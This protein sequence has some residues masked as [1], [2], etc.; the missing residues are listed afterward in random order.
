[1]WKILGL[2]TWCNNSRDVR[3]QRNRVK[4]KNPNDAVYGAKNGTTM[5]KSSE[6]WKEILN[7]GD[8]IM[9]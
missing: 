4:V 2:R 8:G 1:M 9:D 5:H 6:P 3:E 7:H